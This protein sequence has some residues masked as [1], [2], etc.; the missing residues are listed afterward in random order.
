MVKWKSNMQ[1]SKYKIQSTKS[2]KFK[3]QLNFDVQNVR[4]LDSAN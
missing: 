3:I 4:K 2:T 1:T